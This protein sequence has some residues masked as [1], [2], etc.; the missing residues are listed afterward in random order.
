MKKL[1]Q[2]NT[3]VNYGSTGRI[4][5]QI[6]ELAISKGFESYIAYGRKDGNSRSN[7][8]KIESRI[9]NYL[10]VAKTRLTDKHGLGSTNATKDFVKQ[11]KNIN[12]DIIHLHNIHGYYL[13]YKILFDFLNDSEIPVVWTLHDCWSFTGH[14]AYFDYV[15]CSKWKSSCQSCPQL[16][17]YPKSFIDNSK[18]NFETKAKAFT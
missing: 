10:H 11:I 18:F 12:P 7:L 3:V 2:I 4:A 17:S 5:E 8:I 9:G 6:G 15:G 14:C 16:E 1:L 13:N